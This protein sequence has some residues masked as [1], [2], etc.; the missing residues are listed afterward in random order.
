MRKVQAV[1]VSFALAVPLLS[2]CSAYGDYCDVVEDA[3][4][5][6]ANF[7]KKSTKA[8]TEYATLTKE[9]AAVAPEDIAPKWTK[10]S[11]ATGAVAEEHRSAKLDLSDTDEISKIGSLSQ[12]QIDSLNQAYREFND[13]QQARKVVV[14]DVLERCKIDLSQ[15]KK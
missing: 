10:I 13:T 11:E 12:K 5:Q 9:I 4:P 8:F 3:Q 6:L 2:S 1:L 14:A 7:G 15:E